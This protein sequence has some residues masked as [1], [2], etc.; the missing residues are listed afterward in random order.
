ML[1]AVL[2][3]MDCL[4]GSRDVQAAFEDV[5]ICLEMVLFSV[6]H[7]WAFRPDDFASYVHHLV[8]LQKV[9]YQ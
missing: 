9:I 5:I 7:R 8:R 4:Q 2:F 1:L 3:S 6:A